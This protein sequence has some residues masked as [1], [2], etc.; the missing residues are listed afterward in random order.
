MARYFKSRIAYDGEP[1]TYTDSYKVVANDE[2]SDRTV[3]Y[4]EVT[5]EVTKERNFPNFDFSEPSTPH[6][7]KKVAKSVGVSGEY[8]DTHENFDTFN[9][10]TSA[11][12]IADNRG[13]SFARYDGIHYAKNIKNLKNDPEF[14]PTELFTTKPKSVEIKT[15][16]FDPSLNSSFLTVAAMVHQ[17]HGVPLTAS[18][19]LSKWSSAIG[20]NAQERGLPVVSHSENTDMLQTNDIN[21]NGRRPQRMGTAYVN[22]TMQKHMGFV[23]IPDHEVKDARQHLRGLLG[24]EPK[25]HMSPQFRDVPLPG[26]DGF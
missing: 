2:D 7:H 21:D 1:N 25:Q 22:G 20:K 14:Q 6:T 19:N 15:A 23:P 24:R 3:A 4:G 11:R 13:T 5:A 8:L 26:M 9:A 17:K 18:S 12:S 16:H 10:I